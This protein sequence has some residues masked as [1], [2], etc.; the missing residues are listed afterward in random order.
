MARARWVDEAWGLLEVHLLVKHSM[1]EGILEVKLV[2][3][4]SMQDGD[5][6]NHMNGGRLENRVKGLVKFNARLVRKSHT[7]H[8]AL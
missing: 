5:V 6:E 4:P 7:T 8:R 2:D 1:E 3:R